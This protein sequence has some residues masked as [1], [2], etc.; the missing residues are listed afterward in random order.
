MTKWSQLPLTFQQ[1]K[2]SNHPFKLGLSNTFKKYPPSTLHTSSLRNNIPSNT[3]IQ[4]THLDSL[5][6]S[7][8]P[9]GIPTL[10]DVHPMIVCNT[11]EPHLM[12]YPHGS[13]W[14]KWTFVHDVLYLTPLLFLCNGIKYFLC[15]CKFIAN[16]PA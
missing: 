13:R 3:K 11:L 7:L 15:Y 8:P 14:G 16:Y 12:N 1:S 5:L 4:S 9:M 10:A 2:S 6:P